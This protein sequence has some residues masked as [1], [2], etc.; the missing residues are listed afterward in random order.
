[1]LFVLSEWEM[2]AAA[3][4]AAGY[5][6]G[7][8][9]VDVGNNNFLAI[10]VAKANFPHNGVDF[11]TGKPTGRFSNGKNAADFIAEKVGLPTS[12]PYL[13]PGTKNNVSAFL[14]GVSFASGGAG[15]FN[16]TDQVF[17]QSIPLSKQVGNYISV[18]GALVERLGSSATHTH[19][20]K[21]LFTIVVGSN[22]IFDY[23]GSSDLRKKNTPQQYVD[24]MVIKLKEQLKRLYDYGGRKFLVAG[25]GVIGC[26]PAQ[27]V[28]IP[29]HEC[30]EE[31]NHWC[32]QYNERLRSMLQE[33]KSQLHDINYSYF[34]TYNILNNIIQKSST[35][36]FN[37]VNSACC[38]LGELRAKVPC[39]PI[40]KFCSNR[41][42]HVFW[43]LYH[44]TEAASRILVDTIFI[45]SSQDIFP[46]NLQQLINI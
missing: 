41:K 31:V 3:P 26:I 10:S 38:G 4:P 7:D 21:S 8:S 36:G 25:L 27:R 6:F 30:N 37:E 23:F 33:L 44:P 19:L 46:M 40:S 12:P 1:M 11:P 18:Y 28:K 14:T 16:G 5:V 43:D 42:N 32:I 39:I 15:I 20:S 13:S 9:L 2:A 17:G 45:S 34:N 35:F 24:L 22:D 29:T